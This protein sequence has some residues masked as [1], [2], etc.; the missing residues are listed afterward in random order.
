MSEMSTKRYS[1]PRWSKKALQAASMACGACHGHGMVG[2]DMVAQD[3]NTFAHGH[4]DIEPARL[5][6]ASLA[7]AIA[8]AE[9]RASH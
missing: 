4:F 6:H 1:V 8:D 3:G 5:F 9:R 2:I 7:E